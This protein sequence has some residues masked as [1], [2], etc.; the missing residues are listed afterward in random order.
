MTQSLS[1]STFSTKVSIMARTTFLSLSLR[2]VL[3]CWA[4][5]MILALSFKNDRSSFLS[6]SRPNFRAS[7]PACSRS[8][9]FM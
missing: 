2:Y 4:F 8:R 7:N 5:W 3:T 1:T 9:F 6:V